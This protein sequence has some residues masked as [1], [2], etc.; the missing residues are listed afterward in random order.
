[1]RLRSKAFADSERIPTPYTDQG[2]DKSPPL[3]W[4]DA[5]EG[6]REFALMMVDP[7]APQQDVWVHWLMYGISPDMR[8]LPE[9]IER[10]ATVDQLNGVR[11]GCNSWGKNNIGYRGPAPPAG[12]GQHRYYLTLFALGEPLDLEPGADLDAVTAAIDN[13]QVLARATLMGTCER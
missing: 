13:R 5:P 2:E 6:T 10:S 12:H 8:Q 7:D 4:D 11:Q 3:E 1:M 9:G